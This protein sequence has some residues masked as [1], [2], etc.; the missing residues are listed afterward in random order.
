MKETKRQMESKINEKRQEDKE[1]IKNDRQKLMNKM[2][3]RK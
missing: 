3:E 1:E 2:D